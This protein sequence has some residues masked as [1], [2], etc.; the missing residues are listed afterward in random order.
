[1]SVFAGEC[2]IDKW[3]TFTLSC[4]DRMIDTESFWNNK[5]AREVA[6]YCC[7][8]RESAF[9]ILSMYLML[10]LNLS[11]SVHWK[12]FL[13]Y[14]GRHFLFENVKTTKK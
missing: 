1:M 6:V 8:V 5:T 11:L 9:G 14:C 2:L 12:L 13:F 10:S 7:S 4:P 3:N